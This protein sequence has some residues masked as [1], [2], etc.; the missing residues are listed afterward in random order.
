MQ[1]T[2]EADRALGQKFQQELKTD[3]NLAAQLSMVKI[4][5]D[6]GKITLRGSVK[7]EE[8]KK[9]IETAATRVTGVTSV[10]NQLQVGSNPS[11]SP[12]DATDAAPGNSAPK[13]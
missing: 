11:T 6:N 3:S 9:A 13:Q 7:S 12:A 4:G 1:G 5:V 8:Q 10:D 2:T